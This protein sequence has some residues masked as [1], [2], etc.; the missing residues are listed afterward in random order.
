[1]PHQNQPLGPTPEYFTEIPT[2]RQPQTR[3][4]KLSRNSPMWDTYRTYNFRS[5]P[6]TASGV[7]ILRHLIYLPIF[8]PV[9]RHASCANA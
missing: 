6:Q 8:H 5:I 9:Y 7:D 3:T 2:Y 1:M 4:M